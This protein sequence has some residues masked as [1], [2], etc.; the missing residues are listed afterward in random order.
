MFLSQMSFIFVCQFQ[1]FLWKLPE[2]KKEETETKT[3]FCEFNG[4]ASHFYLVD[5]CSVIAPP[6]HSSTFPYSWLRWFKL[7]PLSAVIKL[8]KMTREKTHPFSCVL[9]TITLAV[10]VVYL[11][12]LVCLFPS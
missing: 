1:H 2:T 11:T 6:S 3:P 8:S 4:S 9:L 5:V 7:H 10:H 12:F